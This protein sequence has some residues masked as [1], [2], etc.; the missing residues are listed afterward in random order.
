MV[1]EITDCPL[2]QFKGKTA[3]AIYKIEDGTLTLASYQPGTDKFPPDFDT[4]R[5]A[6]DRVQG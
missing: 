3:N 6:E 1:I 2:P 5:R 4:T